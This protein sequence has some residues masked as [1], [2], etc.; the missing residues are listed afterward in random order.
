MWEK[1]RLTNRWVALIVIAACGLLTSGTTAGHAGEWHVTADV[2]ESCSCDVTCPCNFGS[3][4]THDY[5]HGNRL[6]EVTSG[7]FGGTDISGM[8]FLVTFSMRE[9]AK[10]YVS[11][12]ASDAQMEA[13]E[14]LVPHVLG[15][16]D[17]WGILVTERVPLNVERSPGRL[18]F[19]VPESTVDMNVMTGFNDQPVQIHHLPSAAFQDYTQHKSVTTSHRGGEH[20]FSYSGTTGFTSK[21]DIK[22]EN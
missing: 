7:H 17:N 13:L 4:P 18:K 1:K 21:M 9:W 16:F 14:G 10:L 6:Y 11:D 15:A 2:A 12:D 3:E 5:C 19:S 8:R 22:S 20:E